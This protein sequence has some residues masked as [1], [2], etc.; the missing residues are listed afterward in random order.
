MVGGLAPYA[1]YEK[2]LPD[3]VEPWS[4]RLQANT[5][6]TTAIKHRSCNHT[7]HTNHTNGETDRR[8]PRKH[9]LRTNAMSFCLLSWWRIQNP[10]PPRMQ[11][12]QHLLQTRRWNMIRLKRITGLA[13]NGTGKYQIRTSGNIHLASVHR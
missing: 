11:K 1:E 4:S 2:H 6:Q 9:A 3:L 7:N 5:P 8:T 12:P 13:T 10:D